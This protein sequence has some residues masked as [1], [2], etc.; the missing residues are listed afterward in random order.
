ME[1]VEHINL[2]IISKSK[3]V[4]LFSEYQ[5]GTDDLSFLTLRKIWEIR[6]D[7]SDGRI[8]L[9][10]SQPKAQRNNQEYHFPLSHNKTLNPQ[11]E[12]GKIL[13]RKLNFW[14]YIFPTEIY[15]I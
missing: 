15:N 6:G 9:S 13:K 5:T 1:A 14:Y 2:Q 3:L 11:D 7:P 8:L 4:F 12:L 10:M